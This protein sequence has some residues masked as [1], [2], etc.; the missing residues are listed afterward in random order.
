VILA[1][2]FIEGKTELPGTA[3]D[4]TY[5]FAFTR[6]SDERN[7]HIGFKGHKK[8]AHGDFFTFHL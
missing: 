7:P 5:L 3:I 8:A 2:K 6:A 1:Y 4:P